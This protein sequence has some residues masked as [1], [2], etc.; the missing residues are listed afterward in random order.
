MLWSLVNDEY[1]TREK[2]DT[3]KS[4]I[5]ASA[6][7]LGYDDTLYTSAPED[8]QYATFGKYIKLAEVL[9]KVYNKT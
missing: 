2:E 5:I 8:K 6:N 7:R 1:L 9:A 3:M 4:R